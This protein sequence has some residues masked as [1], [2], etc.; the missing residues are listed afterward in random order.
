MSGNTSDTRSRRVIVLVVDR[1]G[2]A[3]LGP[4]GN[5]WL[6]TPNFNQLASE[7][8]LFEHVLAETL[9]I[10]QFCAGCWS[11]RQPPVNAGD[12]PVSPYL[13]EQC[14]TGGLTTR[15]LTDDDLVAAHPWAQSFDQVEF[16]ESDESNSAQT[17]D[18]DEVDP[19][20]TGIARLFAAALNS[21]ADES[22]DLCWIHAQGM[23]GNWDAPFAFRE[24]F[25]DE[26][27]P[28]PP[29]DV[30]PPTG[31]V[32]DDLDPDELQGWIWSY[33][34]QVTLLDLCLSPL[35]DQWR[36]SSR[37][38]LFVVLG[39]RGYALGEHGVWGGEES[40]HAEQVQLPLIMAASTHTSTLIRTQELVQPSE[41]CGTLLNWLGLSSDPG[42]LQIPETDYAMDADR[43]RQ[44]AICRTQQA[45]GLR[46]PTWYAYIETPSL[47]ETVPASTTAS[48]PP[49]DE[50][51]PLQLFL[52]PDDR[53]DVNN[54][55]DLCP[56]VVR[57]FRE[58]MRRLES[59]ETGR[60]DN[61]STDLPAELTTRP[62]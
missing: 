1:L 41:L 52:K 22:L 32:P 16:V 33:A 3:F 29:P 17:P 54:V 12:N 27:D 8:I 55:A 36:Q 37:D 10:S 5:T 13:L 44:L 11:G 45:W 35:L 62:K 40:L 7:G 18:S 46:T 23:Q 9:D 15:L 51:A 47:D 19:E 26:D 58:L 4:Y 2:A 50:D 25:A 31:P 56:H 60:I 38:T 42:L 21:I 49:R 53:W 20:A 6:D 14:R 39:A 57:G 48:G 61:R 30:E 24:Q 43:S 34:G 59:D 28:L